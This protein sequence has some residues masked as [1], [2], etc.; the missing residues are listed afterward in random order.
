MKIKHRVPTAAYEL[1]SA[2]LTPEYEAEVTRSTERLERAYA[3]AQRRLE[4]AQQRASHAQR[5]LD[6]HHSKQ[7]KRVA[8]LAWAEVEVR[9]AELESLHRQM[10]STVQAARSRGRRSFRPV[11]VSVGGTV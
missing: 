10:T 7:A 5:E 8:R 1:R 3:Q 9:R 11:P 2:V 6:A 4:R